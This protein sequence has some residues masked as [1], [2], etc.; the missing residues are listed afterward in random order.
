[1][2]GHAR[3]TARLAIAASIA[4]VAIAG[5]PAA[6]M[7]HGPTAPIAINYLA[8]VGPTPAG[9]Q[10]KVIDG[11][12][13]LWLTVAPSVTLVVLDYDQAP[14]LRF[15]RSGVQVNR[16][17]EMY[18][19]NATPFPEAVPGGLTARTPPEWVSVSS[20]HTYQWHDGRLSSLAA[21]ALAPGTR[22]IGMWSIRVTVNGRT[23]DLS[24]GLWYHPRPSVVWL[25]FIV[26]SLTCALAAIRVRRPTVDRQLARWLGAVGLIAFAIGSGGH[27]L[28]GR[29]EI[30]IFQLIEL[31]AALAFAGWG[32]HRVVVKDPGYFTYFVI[33]FVTIYEGVTLFP[34]LRDGFVLLPLPAL[35]ARVVTVVCLGAGGSMLLLVF[36]LAERQWEGRGA[37]AVTAGGTG[38]QA[39]AT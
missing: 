4:L 31:A 18:Y 2:L 11:D 9:V 17:S 19:L 25:W 34:T 28:H 38:P 32:I 1:M 6:A 7:A 20:S 22:Y 14:Y 26:V 37:R 33:A 15:D 23:V 35:L 21:T 27:Y 24:G 3:A 10:A 5:A 8:R 16:N 36:R 29:P 12:Q 39:G 30:T 13:R